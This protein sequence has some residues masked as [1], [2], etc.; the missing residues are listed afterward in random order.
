[1][2]DSLKL[3]MKPRQSKISGRRS[4]RKITGF[5]NREIQIILA[6]YAIHFVIWIPIVLRLFP[7]LPLPKLA[8]A[9]APVVLCHGLSASYLWVS[10]EVRGGEKDSRGI[11]GFI[12]G[13]HLLLL[14]FTL[15][16]PFL[17]KFLA[18]SQS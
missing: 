5:I 8:V 14:I 4:C 10:R 7:T 1:M 18:A 12:P 9:V 16:S 13:G 3:P 15:V 6:L 11:E 2:L 17:A